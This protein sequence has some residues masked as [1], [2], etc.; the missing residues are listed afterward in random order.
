MS[1]DYNGGG[2]LE[3]KIHPVLL[4]LEVILT[5]LYWIVISNF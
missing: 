4:I 2:G 3:E 1:P 5:F